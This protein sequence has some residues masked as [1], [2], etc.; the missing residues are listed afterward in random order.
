MHAP[1]E[2]KETYGRTKYSSNF[3]DERKF[4]IRS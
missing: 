3:N 2:E 1:V 4:L